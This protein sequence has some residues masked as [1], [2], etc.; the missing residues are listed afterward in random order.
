LLAPFKPEMMTTYPVGP[1]V[2]NP[3]VESKVCLEPLKGLF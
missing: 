3:A 1:F 2:S